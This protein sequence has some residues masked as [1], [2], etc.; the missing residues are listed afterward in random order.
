M[1][2]LVP[3]YGCKNAGAPKLSTKIIDERGRP[4]QPTHR[5]DDIHSMVAGV[6]GQSR[7]RPVTV[8]LIDC[9]VGHFL[10]G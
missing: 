1:P 6:T 3:L 9:A 2:S 4:G 5:P 8:T 7:F 10:V